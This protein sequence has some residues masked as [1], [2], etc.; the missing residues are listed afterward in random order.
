[1]TGICRI[2]QEA[3]NLHSPRQR[4]DFP[5]LQRMKCNTTYYP[6]WVEQGETAPT[7][8]GE[9]VHA[10]ENFV[11]TREGGER[12]GQGNKAISAAL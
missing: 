1:M 5:F 10:G 12:G 6:S 3:T 8:T 11:K 2:G 7:G 4:S 9:K